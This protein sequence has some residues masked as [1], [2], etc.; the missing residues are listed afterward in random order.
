[1]FRI[2]G[3]TFIRWEYIKHNCNGKR[4]ADKEIENTV[5]NSL[6]KL[7]SSDN[8]PSFLKRSLK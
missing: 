4:K 1:M 6:E 3:D 2:I 5:R 7:K 8:L